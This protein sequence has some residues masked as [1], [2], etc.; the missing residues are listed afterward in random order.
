[1]GKVLNEEAIRHAD[2]FRGFL[3][4][5]KLKEDTLIETLKSLEEGTTEFASHPGFLSPEVLSRYRFHMDCEH[6]LY[7]L[8]SPAVKRLVQER[9]IKLTGY[10]EFLSGK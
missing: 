5:G 4:S 9:G 6:E 1:M 10:R 3:D 7:A 8:T 2:H